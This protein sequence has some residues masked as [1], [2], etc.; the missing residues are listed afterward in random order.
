MAT[1]GSPSAAAG[2]VIGVAGPAERNGQ[3]LT[4]TGAGVPRVLVSDPSARRI[5]RA[6]PGRLGAARAVPATEVQLPEA[7]ITGEPK[8]MTLPSGSTTAPSCWPHSVSWG[9]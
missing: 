7:L 8:R 9:G 2:S 5:H 4:S 3:P 6:A 1:G